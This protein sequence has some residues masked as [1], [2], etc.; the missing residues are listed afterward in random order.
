MRLAIRKAGSARLPQLLAVASSPPDRPRKSYLMR[1]ALSLAPSLYR[2]ASP[3]LKK[4]FGPP[5]CPRARPPMEM[6][7]PY[8]TAQFSLSLSAPAHPNPTT[9]RMSSADATAIPCRDL[10]SKRNK[11]QNRQESCRHSRVDRMNSHEV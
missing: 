5:C 7:M 3:S 8:A 6:R 2:P 1:R 4:A 9:V 11:G 10:H